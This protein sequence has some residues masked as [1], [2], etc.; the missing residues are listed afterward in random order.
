MI[1]HN[2]HVE[3]LELQVEMLQGAVATFK[4]NCVARDQVKYTK[5]YVNKIHDYMKSTYLKMSELD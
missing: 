5:G 4:S 1:A 2:K 3:E